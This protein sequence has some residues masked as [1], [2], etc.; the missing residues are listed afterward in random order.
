MDNKYFHECNTLLRGFSI[1]MIVNPY[2][3]FVKGKSN[4]ISKFIK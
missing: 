3:I 2:D 4:G 1:I